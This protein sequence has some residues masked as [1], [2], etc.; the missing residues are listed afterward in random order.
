MK[1]AGYSVFCAGI[2]SASGSV[3]FEFETVFLEL[4]N[5][6]IKGKMVKIKINSVM[7]AI[8]QGVP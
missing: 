8:E 2:A 7:S 5:C 4:I 6:L 3:I 1:R